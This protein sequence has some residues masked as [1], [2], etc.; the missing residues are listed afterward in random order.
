MAN[1]EA[2]ALDAIERE[3]K[4]YDKVRRNLK[5]QS[6]Q[7]DTRRTLKLTVYSKLSN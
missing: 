4:E 3:A 6:Q 1:N 7:A 2:D 5:P